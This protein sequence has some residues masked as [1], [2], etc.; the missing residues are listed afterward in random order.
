M[1]T[2]ASK[3]PIPLCPFYTSTSF[4]KVGSVLSSCLK[5]FYLFVQKRNLKKN[6]F[7]LPPSVSS[8]PCAIIL[9]TRCLGP[10]LG[11]HVIRAFTSTTANHDPS[12]CST[13][14]RVKGQR[15]ALNVC[16]QKKKVYLPMRLVALRNGHCAL[17]VGAALS[18]VKL[19]KPPSTRPSPPDAAQTPCSKQKVPKLTSW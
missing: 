5:V 16:P 13:V 17:Q 3:L 14:F 8:S 4:C 12:G 11:F 6:A 7:F 10:R 15:P 18:C 9:L 2:I 1:F 19:V